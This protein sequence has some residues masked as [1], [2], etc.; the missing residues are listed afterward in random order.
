MLKAV[1][2]KRIGKE[3]RK[4]K[5]LLGLVD[6][7]IRTAKPVGSNTLKETG[8]GDLSSATIRNYFAQ[9]EEEGFLIQIHSSGGRIPT[10]LA[11]RT[12]ARHCL[13]NNKRD[14]I[15]N[16]F[17]A[18]QNF[19]SREIA[20]LLQKSGDLL[21][22]E[23]QCAVFLSAPRFDHDFVAEI[24]LVP[25][26]ATRCVCILVTDFGVIQTE[27]IPLTAKLSGFAIKR[28]EGYFYWRL[29][30]LEKPENLTN[31]ELTLS[32]NLYN[33]LMVRYIVGYSNFTN[34]DIYRTGFSQLLHYP[35][36][37]EANSLSSGLGLFE[38]LQ[39]MR[40][41]LRECKGH[42]Q[43][44]FWIGDD[45]S[46]LT[47]QSNCSVIT[48]PYMINKKVVG[49]VGV[50]GPTRIH[51]NKLF[52]LLFLFSKE[53]SDSLTKSIYKFKITFRQPEE[54]LR[55]IGKSHLMMLE[56]KRQIE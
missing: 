28:I 56:D 12:Y 55:L 6:Y 39:A 29:T 42:N 47:T 10:N 7:F 48:I 54:E 25:V 45:L 9:L 52:E 40:L 8:F 23:S 33:E 46:S 1:P 20:L 24:K 50:L 15:N 21:S 51:Y 27:V 44:K 37:S 13:E 31:E 3:N 5:V 14:P 16:P 43:M 32:Q 26:D 41:L 19:D 22:Q 49:A 30:G 17:S 36:F 11:Y 35:D 18:I 53:L 2:I 38:N 34:D 4:E